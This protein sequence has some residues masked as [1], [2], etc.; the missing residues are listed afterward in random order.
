MKN[1]YLFVLVFTTVLI[2]V[3]CKKKC[4]Q[5]DDSSPT[6]TLN[7]GDIAVPMGQ[8]F[9]DPGYTAID[10]L[11]INCDKQG[12]GDITSKVTVQSALPI[13]TFFAKDYFVSYRVED[14]D[15]KADATWRHV[16]VQLNLD[17]IVGQWDFTVKQVSTG[18]IFA[19]YNSTITRT[20]SSSTANFNYENYA[21]SNFGYDGSI[22]NVKLSIITVCKWCFG[23]Y[24]TC[25]D[26]DI[27][28]Q[29]VNG[30]TIDL[31]QGDLGL[32]SGDGKHF[33][34]SYTAN[35]VSYLLTATKKN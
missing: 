34:V 33:T 9:V 26:F 1:N 8:P 27:L 15:G 30:Q 11:G 10:N 2:T 24:S 21:L 5:P 12:D 3:S 31:D 19:T 7:G 23:G 13:N 25:T 6:L 4:N 16:F 18:T 32:I 29:I 17:T 35:G 14:S 20:N 22:S 28:P